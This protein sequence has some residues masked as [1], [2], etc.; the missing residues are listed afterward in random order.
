[1]K[2]TIE[3]NRHLIKFYEGIDA[4]TLDDEC[5]RILQEI[6][7]AGWTQ[8]EAETFAGWLTNGVQR[9][10]KRLRDSQPFVNTE[11]MSL[12]RFAKSLSE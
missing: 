3:E 4:V 11:G 12:R 7:E 2:P 1:M 8:H 6:E 10:A 5:D 9:S